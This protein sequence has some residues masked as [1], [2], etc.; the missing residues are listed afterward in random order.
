MA[1]R[2]TLNHAGIQ[3]MLTSAG[4]RADLTGRAARVL[5]AAQSSAPVESG[6]YRASLHIV[7]DT[8]DRAAVRVVSDSPYAL[9]VEANT[10]CLARALDAAR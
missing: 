6:A 8:T 9:V 1:T 7:Q 4:V 10:G 2:V 5:S 3:A